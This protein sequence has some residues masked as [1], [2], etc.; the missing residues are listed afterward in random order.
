MWS[1]SGRGEATRESSRLAAMNSGAIVG[2]KSKASDRFRALVAL[3]AVAIHTGALVGCA[4]PVGVLEPV[5]AQTPGATR[6]DIL[7]ATTRAPSSENGVLFSGERGETSLSSIAV[8]IPPDD[9][10][11]IGQVQWPRRT[12]PDPAAEFAVM[13]VD[14]LK[15]LAQADIWIR[16]QG[17]KGRRVL[18]FV[19]GFNTRFENALFSFAQIVHDSGAEAAPV[20]FSW[21]SRGNLFEYSYDRE[22]ANISRDSF[23]TLLARLSASPSVGEVTILAHSVG[24]WLTMETLRQ[25]AIRRGKVPARIQTVILAS[26]DIDVDLFRAQLTSLGDKRP[27]I[28]V[29]VSRRDRA[30]RLSRSIAGNIERLGAADPEAKPWIGEKGVEVVDLTGVSGADITRHS[31]FSRDPDVVR[32]LGAQLINGGAQPGVGERVGETA[33][34]LAQGVA[35]VTGLTLSA[36]LAIVDPEFRNAHSNQLRQTRQA[37]DNAISAGLDW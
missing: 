9:R 10:R 5:S 8:S 23:E 16:R 20:L 7:V 2:S 21:P 34:G 1:P 28:V 14:P 27:H 33:M 36:P 24:A 6:L 15:D 30:L 22:S 25:M 29:F 26:P 32:F 37:V 4:A 31:K 18:V 19:H 3:C 12:P 17:I 13:R 11:R 35:G